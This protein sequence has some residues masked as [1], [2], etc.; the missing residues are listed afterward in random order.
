MFVVN[1]KT[2]SFL[3]FHDFNYPPSLDERTLDQSEYTLRVAGNED[4]LTPLQ[5]KD[6]SREKGWDQGWMVDFA[7]PQTITGIEFS[8]YPR[9]P[10]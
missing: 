9:K 4:T 5:N 3:I 1:S 8:Q 6:V 7:M 10:E 2:A